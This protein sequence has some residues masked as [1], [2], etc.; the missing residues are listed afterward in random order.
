M[1][2]SRGR[3]ASRNSNKTSRAAS[4]IPGRTR[5]AKRRPRSG[6]SPDRSHTKYVDDVSNWDVLQREME[7]LDV[8]AANRDQEV[9][10]AAQGKDFT[11]DDSNTPPF[12]P[13]KSNKPG[14]GPHGEHS[15]L[16]PE[17]AI[18]HMKL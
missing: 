12:L 7:V 13:V 16:D 8:M 4:R 10:A 6:D 5:L 14:P 17:E 15:F 1:N 3:Q 11:V 18:G 9:W 2:R